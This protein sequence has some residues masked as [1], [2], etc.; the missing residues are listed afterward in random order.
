MR[1]TRWTTL[2]LVVSW[3]VLASSQVHQSLA[4]RARESD[5]V[6][7]AEVLATRVEVPAEGPRRM[8]TV[9]TLLV[10]ERYKGDSPERL[11]VVQLG[12]KSGLWESR[13]AGDAAFAPGE[14]AVLFLKCGEATRCNL[15]GLGQGKLKLEGGQVEVD[16]A[17]HPLEWA[18][19]EIRRGGRWV[20]RPIGRRP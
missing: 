16:G 3:A 13:V 20:G 14:T 6:V 12:G 19:D 18:V 5:R 10:R 1:W 9:T 15:V 2:P 17:R 8:R 11:E 4:D 7:L